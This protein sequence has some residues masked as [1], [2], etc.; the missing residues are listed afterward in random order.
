MKSLFAFF[1]AA[2]VAGVLG[3]ASIA[4]AADLV[5][6]ITPSHD[7]PFFK[8]EADGAAARAKEL[9]Y[10]TIVLVHDDDANKQSELIDTAIARGAKAIILDNAG[11]DASVAGVKK[12]KD[13]GLSHRPRDQCNRNCDRANRLQQLSGRATRR[14][15]IRE[16]DGRK[17]Q[18]RRARRQGIRHQCRHPLP[19]L[20]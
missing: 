18:L 11:A 6:I 8:A 2:A 19:G 14:A 7:N 4:R 16:A 10:D 1:G 13:S 17:G 20:S 3:A 12:A 5:A 15:R 9:G